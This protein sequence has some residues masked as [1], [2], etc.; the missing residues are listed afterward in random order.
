MHENEMFV[1]LTDFTNGTLTTD[2]D[3]HQYRTRYKFDSEYLWMADSE[4]YCWN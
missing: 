2:K 4:I 3:K 1:L